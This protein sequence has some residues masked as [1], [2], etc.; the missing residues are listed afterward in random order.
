MNTDF[1][2]QLIWVFPNGPRLL[3]C[4]FRVLCV[5]ATGEL[6]PKTFHWVDEIISEPGDGMLFLIDGVAYSYRYFTVIFLDP[7]KFLLT[8][9]V[10]LRPE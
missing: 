7:S 2:K 5:E 1:N 8:T 10:F 9:P 3:K 6:L 4:P